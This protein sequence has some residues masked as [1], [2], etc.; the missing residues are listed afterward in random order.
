MWIWQNWNCVGLENHPSDK[1]T[2]LVVGSSPT[3]HTKYAVV[4]KQ[5]DTTDL[6]SVDSNVLRVQIPPT[7]PGDLLMTVYSN[8]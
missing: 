1:G 7:A 3:I 5:E 8:P 4:V 2:N 6:K